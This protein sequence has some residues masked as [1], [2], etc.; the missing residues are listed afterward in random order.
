MERSRFWNHRPENPSNEC[1]A[2]VLALAWSNDGTKLA[3]GGLQKLFVWDA[4]NWKTVREFSESKPV[5]GYVVWSPDDMKLAVGH[6]K[7]VQIWDAKRLEKVHEFQIEP[8]PL[9]ALGWSPDGASLA[10]GQAQGLVQLRETASGAKLDTLNL[11]STDPIAFHWSSDGSSLAIGC[12]DGT[13]RVWN[14][15]TGG[16]RRQAS[17]VRM[18]HFSPYGDF[19][20][21][22][23]WSISS[24]PA[25]VLP[26]WKWRSCRKIVS[27]RRKCLY[28]YWPDGHFRGSPL[29][30]RHLVYVAQ[31]DEGQQVFT[32]QEFEQRFGWRNDPEKVR[33]LDP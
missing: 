10:V 6:D 13:I 3:G 11:V 27:S 33:L 20:L 31:T 2:P 30:E 21:F 4:A 14:L 28:R 7:D 9:T 29:V 19:A 23:E 17:G 12:D 26:R 1:E 24:R 18:Q 5:F 8:Q 16:V 32:P 22:V 15:G 25:R